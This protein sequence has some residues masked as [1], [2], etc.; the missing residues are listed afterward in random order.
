MQKQEWVFYNRI[1]TMNP[2]FNR[3][4]VRRFLTFHV[5]KFRRNSLR[6]SP[7]FKKLSFSHTHWVYR[8]KWYSLRYHVMWSPENGWPDQ[9]PADSVAL[10]ATV[11]AK[12][13]ISFVMS[14]GLFCSL[15][16]ETETPDVNGT[17]AAVHLLYQPRF[18]SMATNLVSNLTFYGKY[19][20]VIKR[21]LLTAKNMW[22]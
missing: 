5:S 13:S 8:K 1:T 12:R 3:T 20:P 11:T 21:G 19:F 16:H 4:I 22:Q 2:G 6:K 10:V 15:M 9:E 18:V 17:Y 7:L 14:V